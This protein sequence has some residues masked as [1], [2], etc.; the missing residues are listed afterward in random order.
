[1]VNFEIKKKGKN[2]L[3]L[4]KKQK[5]KWK[6]KKNAFFLSIYGCWMIGRANRKVEAFHSSIEKK[7]GMEV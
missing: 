4:K 2:I 1:M 5:K 3:Y 7:N 6:K